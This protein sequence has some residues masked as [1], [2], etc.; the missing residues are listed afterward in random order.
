MER[1]VDNGRT[2][3]LVRVKGS[4]GIDHALLNLPPSALA[5]RLRFTNGPGQREGEYDADNLKTRKEEFLIH[6]I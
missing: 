6:F 1:D 3:F 2:F 4:V 5:L